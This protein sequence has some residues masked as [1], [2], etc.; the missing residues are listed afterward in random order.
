MSSASQAGA[1]RSRSTWGETTGGVG[2]TWTN[3]TNAGGTQ[4]PSIA[5]NQTVAIACKL[6]GFRVQDGNTWW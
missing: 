5:S 2:H 6:T 4:G 3:Y 1:S